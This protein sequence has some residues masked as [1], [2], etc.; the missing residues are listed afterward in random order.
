MC[1]EAGQQTTPHWRGTRV[2][3][4]G[5]QSFVDKQLPFSSY[6]EVFRFYAIRYDSTSQHTSEAALHS[7]LMLYAFAIM[8]KGATEEERE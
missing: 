7:G 1:A 6:K 5:I 4:V 8:A 2:R 3:G